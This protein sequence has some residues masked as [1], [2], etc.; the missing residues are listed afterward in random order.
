VYITAGTVPLTVMA[1]VDSVVLAVSRDSLRKLDSEHPDV[2]ILFHRLVMQHTARA[3]SK[4]VKSLVG[5]LEQWDAEKKPSKHLD[6]SANNDPARRSVAAQIAPMTME[7]HHFDDQGP[8][9]MA[10]VEPA[11]SERGVVQGFVETFQSGTQNV[12]HSM[13]AGVHTVT[14]GTVGAV[15]GVKEITENTLHTSLILAGF[16]K[17]DEDDGLLDTSIIASGT[18]T[19]SGRR[20]ARILSRTPKQKPRSESSLLNPA[21]LSVNGRNKVCCAVAFCIL[22]LLYLRP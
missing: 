5:A 17:N 2:A 9:S 10:A 8:I 4:L 15:M 19:K 14:Q 20:V 11:T 13:S 12:V 22:L 6:N 7:S 21:E 16:E 3:K 18:G 1:D